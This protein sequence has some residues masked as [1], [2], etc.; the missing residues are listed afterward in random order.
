MVVFG[1]SGSCVG[2][3]SYAGKV[4]VATV[5]KEER[6]VLQ[7]RILARLLVYVVVQ[8]AAKTRKHE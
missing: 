3:L 1:I 6:S 8:Q 7:F 2:L 4:T 5:K